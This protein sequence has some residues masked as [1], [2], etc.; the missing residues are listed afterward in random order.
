MGLRHAFR[1]LGW[2]QRWSTTAASSSPPPP[3]S[4]AFY[5]NAQLDAYAARKPTKVTLKQL[6]DFGAGRMSEVK[7]VT[8]A[9]F[10]RHEVA[11][12]L[13]RRLADFQGLPYIVGTAAPLHDVYTLYWGSFNRFRNHPEIKSLKVRRNR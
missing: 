5:Q 4:D 3:P 1:R 2:M 9:N 11:V 6:V 12:R 8:S 10:V 13:A 7:L